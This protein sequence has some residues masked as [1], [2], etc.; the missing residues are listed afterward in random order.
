ML[1]IQTKNADQHKGWK[2][3]LSYLLENDFMFPEHGLTGEAPEMLASAVKEQIIKKDGVQYIPK[4]TIFTFEQFKKLYSEI[5]E[6]LVQLVKP[7]TL[8]LV[9]MFE[10]LNTRS[11]PKA[12]HD[13]YIK[14]WTYFNIWDSGIKNFMFA[15]EDGYLYMPETPEDG[16][17]LT[18]SFVY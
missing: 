5:F 2:I 4:F 11:L 1:T 3:M 17:S 16:T 13:S 14:R 10:E 12:N 7:Q 15:A 18:L 8:E 9:K 6:P